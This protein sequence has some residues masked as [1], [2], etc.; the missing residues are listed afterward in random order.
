MVRSLAFAAGT[1]TALL[2]LSSMAQAQ[3][4]TLTRDQLVAYTAQNPFER[5]PDG[6]PK[7]PDALLARIDA[8]AAATDRSRS[9]T[10][11]HLLARGAA[12]LERETRATGEPES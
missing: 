6:R 1:A 12:I 3:L 10:I 8:L 9:G 11:R 5:F 2:L 7:V 4:F